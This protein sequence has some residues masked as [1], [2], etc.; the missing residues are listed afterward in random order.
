MRFIIIFSILLI[1]GLIFFYGIYSKQNKNLLNKESN[2]SNESQISI[3]SS[4]I[5][6][7]TIR[8]TNNHWFKLDEDI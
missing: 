6:Q 3:S 2:T 4:K 5:K 7:E 8:R 1:I